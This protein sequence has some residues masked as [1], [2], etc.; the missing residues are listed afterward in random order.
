MIES[1][2]VGSLPFTGDLKKFLK[3]ATS[4][5]FSVN[6]STQYFEERVV[7][8]FIDKVEAGIDVP[9]FPQFRDMNEMVLT[10]I[11][12]L[13]KVKGGYMETGVLSLKKGEIPEVAAIKNAFKEIYERMGKPVKVKVCVAGP[14]TL[15]SLFIYK[16]DK[17]FTRLGDMVSRVVEN[18]LFSEKHGR[19]SLISVD[20]PVFGLLDDPLMD[21]GSEGRENLRKAWE[22]IFHKASARGV[23]TCLHLHSTT[24]ELFW[25]VKTL[26]IIE[27]HADDPLYQMKKTKELLESRDKFLKASICIADFDKLIRES[28]IASSKEK[29]SELVVNERI[30]ETWKKI[31]KGELDSK[32][33]LEGVQLMEK[34]LI[35][36]V[37]Q[38]SVERVPYA[39]PECGLKGF[40]TYECALE[41]LRRVSGAVKKLAKQT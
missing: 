1:C 14:Y 12:G 17:I 31:S 16:D 24:D 23:Q 26:N 21:R 35:K 18:N 15:S 10:T 2:D 27:S 29:M 32:S 37:N 22:S 38:F 20:E 33:L 36:I 3:G 40:P 34:R 9:N 41:C 19:V 13:E 25:D 5:G 8:A 39:A 6:D 7:E 28:I 11:E 4:H 30:A